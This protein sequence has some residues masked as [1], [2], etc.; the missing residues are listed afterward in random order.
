MISIS[1]MNPESVLGLVEDKAVVEI[2]S[3]VKGL[4]EGAMKSLE[5]AL[6]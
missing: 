4:I 5:V 1:A 6:L 2:A 3:K